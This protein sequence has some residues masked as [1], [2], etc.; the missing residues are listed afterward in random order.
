MLILLIA[1]PSHIQAEL[2]ARADKAAC[3]LNVTADEDSDGAGVE[4]R[5]LPKNQLQRGK[6]VPNLREIKFTPVSRA[7]DIN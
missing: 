7:C 6:R 4:E 1:A 5:D 2:K 3:G